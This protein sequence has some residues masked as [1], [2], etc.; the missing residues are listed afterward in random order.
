MIF[1]SL[2][3][4]EA[5]VQMRACKWASETTVHTQGGLCYCLWAEEP[6]D[7]NNALGKWK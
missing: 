2:L 6:L 3:P 1:D 4:S 7:P 5:E